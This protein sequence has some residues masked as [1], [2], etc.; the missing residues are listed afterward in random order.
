MSEADELEQRIK[1]MDEEDREHFKTLV[2]NLSKCYAEDGPRAVVTISYP[3]G[4][5]ETFTMNCD[6]EDAYIVA[7]STTAFLEFSITKDAPPKERM[8]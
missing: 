1:A 2:V 4:M 3:N 5:D 7:Q 6:E 8:N